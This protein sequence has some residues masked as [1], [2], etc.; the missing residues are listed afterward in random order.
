MRTYQVV[1]YFDRFGRVRGEEKG[2][3][4]SPDSTDGTLYGWKVNY[5]FDPY[6]TTFYYQFKREE[7]KHYPAASFDFRSSHRLTEKEATR[8]TEFYLDSHRRGQRELQDEFHDKIYQFMKLSGLGPVITSLVEGAF[9]AD[10]PFSR[11]G[12]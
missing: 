1:E 4:V 8:L 3:L 7:N 10:S 2:T 12:W 6:A 9:R 11:R 5:T